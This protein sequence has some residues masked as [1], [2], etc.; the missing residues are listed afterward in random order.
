MKNTG[1]LSESDFYKI[2]KDQ[3][4][5]LEEL[6]LDIGILQNYINQF[7]DMLNTDDMNQIGNFCL[8]VNPSRQLRH[9]KLI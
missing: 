2:K 8:T 5:N 3:L 6:E 9:L 1:T 7:R 4:E